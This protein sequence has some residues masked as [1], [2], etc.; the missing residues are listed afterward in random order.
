MYA[1]LNRKHIFKYSIELWLSTKFRFSLLAKL[2][3]RRLNFKP[4]ERV[5]IHVCDIFHSLLLI[6]FFFF[7]YLFSILFFRFFPSNNKQKKTRDLSRRTE[8]K[9]EKFKYDWNK[10]KER[11]HRAVK[12]KSLTRKFGALISHSSG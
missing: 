12:N 11:S 8:K 3:M 2:R 9:P 10:K 1:N 7:F 4:T 5:Y 6:L